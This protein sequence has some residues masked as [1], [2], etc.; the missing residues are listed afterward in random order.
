[1]R[2]RMNGEWADLEDR[3]IGDVLR[4]YGLEEK[5]VVVEA[6]GEIIERALWDSTPLKDGMVLEIVHFV[7]GG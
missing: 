7:G 1:M 6:N 5:R 3:T 2:V 4:R